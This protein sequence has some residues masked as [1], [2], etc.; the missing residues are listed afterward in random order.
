MKKLKPLKVYDPETVMSSDEM[1]R[2]MG[3]GYKGSGYFACTCRCIYAIGV[4]EEYTPSGYC[5]HERNKPFLTYVCAETVG[6][7]K[8]EGRAILSMIFVK[9]HR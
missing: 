5:P 6:C 7:F 3:G 1:K 4:W 2:I 8:E 9:K